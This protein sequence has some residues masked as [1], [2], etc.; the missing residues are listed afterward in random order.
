[1]TC[2]LQTI[3]IAN[4][5]PTQIGAN[6]VDQTLLNNLDNI[7]IGLSTETNKIHNF[8]PDCKIPMEISG[9]EYNCKN[10]GMTRKNEKET[11]DHETAGSANIHISTGRNRGQIYNNNSDYTKAQKK[12]ILDQLNRNS[13]EYNGTMIPHNVLNATATQYN[14]IQKF[15]TED[16]IDGDGNVKNQKKFVRRGNIKDEVIA[17]L[18]KWEGRREGIFLKNRDIAKFMKLSTQ[19]FARGEDIIRTLVAEGKIDLPMDDDSV[20][21]FCD[22]YLEALNIEEPQYSKYGVFI[23]DLIE[24]SENR[25]IGMNSQ[26]SSKVV[27]A[28]W[29]I[30]INCNLNISSQQLE[31]ATDN[32]KKNTFVKF[33]KSV[34]EN[35]NVFAPIF[36]KHSI[37]KLHI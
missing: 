14:N 10:C 3:P 36:T 5:H 35:L 17:A 34:T 12:S 31:K 32:T 24:E 20:E 26:I 16:E 29:I 33:Y 9:T 11:Y 18:L 15:I 19:G 1:M 7:R 37:P 28:I 6:I 25:K 23:K 22:R 2:N 21:G 30:I 13:A 4:I 27:G 8:C